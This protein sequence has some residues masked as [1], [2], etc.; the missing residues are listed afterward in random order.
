MVYS[1]TL[2]LFLF[3]KAYLAT[4]QNGIAVAGMQICSK[5]CSHEARR[6]RVCLH[7][8]PSFCWH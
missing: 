1:M 4:G 3:R 5:G 7:A 2:L 8:K 6:I